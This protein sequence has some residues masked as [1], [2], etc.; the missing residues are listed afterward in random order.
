MA[1]DTQNS[2]LNPTRDDFAALLDQSLGSKGM[3]EGRVMPATV[4]AIEHDFVVVDIGLKTEGR[5]PLREF[6]VDDSRPTEAGA[7][8]SKFIS[9][10][11]KT[12]SATLSSAARR[13]AA[14]KPGRVLKSRLRRKKPSMA[15]SSAA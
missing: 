14:K 11:S 2:S 8:S 12:R 3:I 1:S 7:T 5:I 10:A 15:R 9:T 4:V 13:R 6:L